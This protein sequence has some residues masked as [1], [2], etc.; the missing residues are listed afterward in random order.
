MIKLSR[1]AA[2]ICV[3]IVLVLSFA[4]RL[5]CVECTQLLVQIAFRGRKVFRNTH[6][7]AQ[8]EIAAPAAEIGQSLAAQPQ[9]L[10]RLRP[11][12]TL[13]FTEP[14]TVGT[15]GRVPSTASAMS[16]VS[17]HQRSA[18]EPAKRASEELRTMT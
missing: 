1:I 8:I 14:S 16:I 18:L 7:D 3:K 4:R 6:P 11:L 17:M 12:G 2:L 10:F 15:L 9:H 13:T 5:L